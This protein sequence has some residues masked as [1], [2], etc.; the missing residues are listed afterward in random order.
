[1][2]QIGDWVRA[3]E[4]GLLGCGG[5]C[6]VKVVNAKC[7]R[8]FFCFLKSFSI[9]VLMGDLHHVHW[10]IIGAP[11]VIKCDFKYFFSVTNLQLCHV[12]LSAPLETHCSCVKCEGASFMFTFS[13]PQT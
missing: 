2:G 7:K 1:M 13:L 9:L 8:V 11:S 10:Q 12:S 6:V 5:C 4:G 3:G